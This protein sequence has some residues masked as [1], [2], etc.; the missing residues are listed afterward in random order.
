MLGS[1]SWSGR[2]RRALGAIAA[3]AV[4]A[5]A[6]C[7]G[8][9]DQGAT[10]AAASGDGDGGGGG[11]VMIGF[12]PSLT[13]MNGP[14]DSEVLKGARIRVDQINAEGGAGGKW[15]LDLQ[16]QDAASDPA[17][18]RVA[19]QELLGKGANFMIGSCSGAVSTPSALLSAGKNV[20]TV[21]T[22]AGESAFPKN[23]GEFGFLSVAGS[24][25]MGAGL[26]Q[27]AV[28]DKDWKTA[29]VVGSDGIEYTVELGT[30]F[31]DAYKQ[32]GG[33]VVAEDKV[34]LFK[35]SY[36]AAVNKIKAFKGDYDV[37]MTPL[38]V[39]DLN[40]FLSELRAAGI[41]KPVL[42][43]DGADSPL[44][45][46]SGNPGEVYVATFGFPKEGSRFAEFAE[47][48][49]TEHKRDVPSANPGLGADIIDLIS[50]AVVKAGSNDSRALRDAFASLEDVEA[51]TGTISYEGSPFG[52]GLADRA[53]VIT[54]ADDSGKAF[55]HAADVQV[56]P[57]IVPQP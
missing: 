6:A 45:F 20:S 36:A 15:K 48:Y 47:S 30:S 9:D 29:Y 40:A 50:A 17:K 7:G 12:T 51:T 22:C 43:A 49:R 21:L 25:H 34:D 56:D 31:K 28:K 57:A 33:E 46:E 18:Q 44:L 39:P 24:L 4:F 52:V 11:T 41:D 23:V 1:T 2:G 32:L 35:Q 54:T 42:L 13:G 26:A 14:F 37:I 5:L 27:F 8:D 10:T 3:G 19:T 53:L 16:V 38:F 55:A